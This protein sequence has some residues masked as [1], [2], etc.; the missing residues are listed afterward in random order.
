MRKGN[1]GVERLNKIS[2]QYLNPAIT[3]KAGKEVGDRLLREG[4]KVMQTKNKLPVRVG[5]LLLKYGMTIDKGLGVLATWESSKYQHLRG[6]SCG[7]ECDE[8]RQVKYPPCD[9]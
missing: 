1:L 9:S 8:Q 2:W 6:D 4:D 5:S 7:F 3:P